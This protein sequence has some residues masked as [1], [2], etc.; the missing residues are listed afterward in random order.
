MSREPCD[1]TAYQAAFAARIRDP[2]R[3]P[4]PPGA[5]AKR[6]R[7][8]EELLFNNLEG[9][10]LACYPVTRKILGARVWKRAA[11]RF[12][13]EHRC[14][15]PLFRDIPKAFL[16]WMEG[17]AAGLF[18]ELPFL[19]E[20]MHYEWLE[21]AVGTTP[22]EADPASVDPEGDLLAGRPALKPS[23]RLACYRYAV[24]LIGPR[25]KP[26]APDAEP[27][28]YLLFRDAQDEVRFIQLNPLSA[29]L[30]AMLRD[31]RPVGREALAHLAG[32]RAPDQY[33]LY[34][35]AGR[36]LLNKLLAQGA[37]LGTWREP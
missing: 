7:V 13:I 10:L 17:R 18:P 37:L 2:G 14:H 19:A 24:H 35:R 27:G 11:R 4:R 9:F 26:V 8:Y 31:H 30:V 23:A 36:E 1:F 33:D 16:D 21:L 15:S 29:R 22:E 5:P 12:F 25:H 3:A 6:M 20:F 28:C 34:L 32:Q